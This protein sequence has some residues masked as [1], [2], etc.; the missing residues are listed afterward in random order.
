[1]NVGWLLLALPLWLLAGH[2]MRFKGQPPQ[3]SLVSSAV[4]CG[5]RDTL[6]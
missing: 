1:M 4:E 6:L 3:R 5:P 2:A